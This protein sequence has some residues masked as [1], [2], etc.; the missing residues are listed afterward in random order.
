M[1]FTCALLLQTEHLKKI[2]LQMH[3][4]T[5]PLNFNFLYNSVSFYAALE[6]KTIL[7][8]LKHS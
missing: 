2:N 8:P 7:E 5:A 6:A 1:E 4:L 3:I